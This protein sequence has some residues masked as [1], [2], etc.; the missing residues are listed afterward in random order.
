ML[1]PLPKIYPFINNEQLADIIRKGKMIIKAQNPPKCSLSAT[2]Q[3]LD[4]FHIRSILMPANGFSQFLFHDHL[5]HNSLSRH[6]AIQKLASGLVRN[7]LSII[8]E[9]DR[10]LS[11]N[12]RKRKQIQCHIFNVCLQLGDEPSTTYYSIL[13]HVMPSFRRR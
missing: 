10:H 4:K 13:N 6:Y 12:K 2:L 8:Q 1:L 5:A 11:L 9:F 7:L 3:K